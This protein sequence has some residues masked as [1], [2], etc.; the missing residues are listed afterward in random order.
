MHSESAQA[1]PPWCPIADGHAFA[2]IKLRILIVCFVAAA[3]GFTSVSCVRLGF[4]LPPSGEDIVGGDVD[5]GGEPNTVGRDIDGD[6]IR[7]S[8]DTDMDGD[9]IPNESDT[10][11]DGDLVPDIRD[12]SCPPDY[13]V[14]TA[15]EG[16]TVWVPCTCENGECND[17]DNGNGHCVSCEEDYFGADCDRECSCLNGICEQNILGQG[18]CIGPCLT[19]WV[20]ENCDECVGNFAGPN[21]DTCAPHFTGITC[22][23]CAADWTGTNCEIPLCPAGYAPSVDN[24]VCVVIDECVALPNGGCDV[25]AQCE[26]TGSGRTCTCD[27]GYSG[28]GVLCSTQLTDCAIVNYNDSTSPD[29]LYEVDPDGSGPSA[30]FQTY[31][32]MKTDGGGWTL[33]LKADGA[34]PTFAYNATHW[35]DRGTYAADHPGFDGIEAKLASYSLVGFSQVLVRMRDASDTLRDLIIDQSANSMYDLIRSGTYTATSR[36]PSEWDSLMESGFL[37]GSCYRQGFNS[38]SSQY[39]VRIGILG[40]NNADCGSPN[41]F[42]GV[43]ATASEFGGVAAGNYAV[44][45]LSTQIRATKTFSYVFVRAPMQPPSALNYPAAIIEGAVGYPISHVPSVVGHPMEYTVTPPLP[46]GLALNTSTGAISGTPV[47]ATE[48]RLYT[49]RAANPLGTTA[50]DISIVITNPP[51]RDCAGILDANPAAPSGIYTIDS[52]G[53]S[54]SSE[55]FE[56]YCDMSTSGG[57]WTLV[58]KADGTKSTFRYGALYWTDS[59]LLYLPT[60]TSFDRNEAKLASFTTVAVSAVHVAMYDSGDS[61]T[62]YLPQPIALSQTWPSIH[63]LMSTGS[64]VS[65]SLTATD[66][67]S[68]LS[69]STLQSNCNRGGFNVT[70][71]LGDCASVRVGMHGNNEGSCDSNDSFIGIGG[72]YSA[73]GYSGAISVGNLVQGGSNVNQAAFGYLFV[74]EGVAIP[75]AFVYSNPSPIYSI[76][77]GIIPNTPTVSGHPCNF[78]ISPALPEG[79]TIDIITGVIIG[80]PVVGASATTYSVTAQNSKGS[81]STSLT[82]EVQ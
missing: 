67:K 45:D 73:G 59:S 1:S 42:I 69:S 60:N 9:G 15:A 68:L 33:V 16:S 31:C 44:D 76:G 36:G 50:A 54:G 24:L 17:G 48:A 46:T 53:P 19:G 82:I 11:M 40:D 25:H 77:T 43:G 49:I 47:T 28:D 6:G 5:S 38:N 81:I 52:D 10:D 66:W 51:P 80:T 61:V 30:P 63:A 29:G 75:S 79:L 22:S 71:S 7:N 56:N 27:P 58:L 4:E 18:T 20:G 78:A 35:S 72:S 55:P 23:T 74:R 62:R 21:C 14:Q 41:S 65:S 70:P 3:Q 32:D 34:Q 37:Y 12:G 26:N 57:G 64:F 39:K 2:H 13:F 8:R